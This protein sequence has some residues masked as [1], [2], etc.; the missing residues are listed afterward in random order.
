MRQQSPPKPWAEWNGRIYST[1]A[2]MEGRMGDGI[3]L[4]EHA[5]E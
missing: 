5:H 1:A 2:L 4:Y 3:G